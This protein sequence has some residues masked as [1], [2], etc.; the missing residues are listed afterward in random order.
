M[1]KLD[2][3]I[4]QLTPEVYAALRQAVELGKWPNGQALTDEQKALCMEGV[5]R[6][7]AVHQVP[8]TQR[9]GYVAPKPPK[10]QPCD[11]EPIHILN[12][13]A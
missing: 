5:I 12:P 13:D 11:H 6:Y 7:E 10:S 9:V 1:Q 2:D 3:L 4:Q 8:E